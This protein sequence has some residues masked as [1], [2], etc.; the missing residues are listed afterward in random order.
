[1]KPSDLDDI[2]RWSCDTPKCQAP[3]AYVYQRIT[4]EAS[5]LEVLFY[6][7]CGKHKLKKALKARKKK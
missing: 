2:K 7:R 6:G 5:T 1:M 3:A 4:R